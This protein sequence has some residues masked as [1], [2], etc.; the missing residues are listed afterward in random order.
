MSKRRNTDHVIA[1]PGPEQ[2]RCNHCGMVLRFVLPMDVDVF[3]AA[4]KAFVKTHANCPPPPKEE[5]DALHD[6]T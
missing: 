2:A 6:E 4:G 1:G 5:P 3:V